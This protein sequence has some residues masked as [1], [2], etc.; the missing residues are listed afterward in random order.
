MTALREIRISRGTLANAIAMIVL[1]RPGPRMVTTASAVTM[2]RK[3]IITS[4]KN[5]TT[6]STV[7]S[8]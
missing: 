6:R 3:V 5:T 1:G 2:V 7:L 4:Q 8:K